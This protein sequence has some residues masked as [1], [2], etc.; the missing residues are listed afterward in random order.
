MASADVRHLNRAA[1]VRPG[2]A[3]VTVPHS[4]SAYL[5]ASLQVDVI[6]NKKSTSMELHFR[7][8]G[9]VGLSC[10][11]TQMPFLHELSTAADLIVK[12][13]EAY[14]DTNDEVLILPQGEH[15]LNVAQVIYES[16]VLAIPLKRVH[17]DVESGK[18]K[19]EIY[20]YENLITEDKEEKKKPKKDAD[21]TDP[22]WDKLK[23]LLN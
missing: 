3:V 1:V 6:L 10:D 15:T 19:P 13:G 18:I 11:L 20:G 9:T 12:F 22:R 23:D 16:V 4:E 8:Q 5:S 14:D 17:P 2:P 7:I 21:D